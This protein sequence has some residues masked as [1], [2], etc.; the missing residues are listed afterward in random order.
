MLG[1]L[2]YFKGEILEINYYIFLGQANT[3]EWNQV[4]APTITKAP[5]VKIR[6]IYEL[7]FLPKACHIFSPLC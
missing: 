7:Y 4:Q 5:L 1:L 3:G 6:Q 2:V